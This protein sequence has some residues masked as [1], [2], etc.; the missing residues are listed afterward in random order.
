MG[1]HPQPADALNQIATICGR[2]PNALISNEC[3]MMKSPAGSLRIRFGSKAA[4]DP[5]VSREQFAETSHQP[6]GALTTPSVLSGRQ[7]FTN[8]GFAL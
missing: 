7:P 6:I 4:P 1:A 3:L 2:A 8:P 5:M